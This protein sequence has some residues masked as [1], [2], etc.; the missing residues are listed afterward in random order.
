MIL[1]QSLHCKH[2]RCCCNHIDVAFRENNSYFFTG[3]H[4]INQNL[5]QMKQNSNLHRS[6]QMRKKKKKKGKSES[7]QHVESFLGKILISL[8]PG[9]S[10]L[11]SQ[12]WE[13]ISSK[14]QNFQASS[15]E[16]D[17]LEA[18][19][20]DCH[21]LP[22]PTTV[23]TPGYLTKTVAGATQARGI[24]LHLQ[25]RLSVW[26]CQGWFV[27]YF[28]FYKVCVWQQFSLQSQFYGKAS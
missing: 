12:R 18:Q 6:Y 22:S 9:F 20:R 26:T 25:N 7:K 2:I 11:F 10:R 1:S 8:Q 19:T 23:F 16:T 14:H 24:N 5:K 28:L 21:H 17:I 27:L 13:L 3:H 15:L 4:Y